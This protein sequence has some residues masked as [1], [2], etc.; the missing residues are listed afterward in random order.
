MNL[1]FEIL[2]F[3]DSEDYFDSLDLQVL[4]DKIKSWGFEPNI[5]LV[6]KAEDFA[7]EHPFEKYDLIVVDYDLQ[8][9]GEGSTLISGIRQQA[10]FTE[11]IFYSAK[12]ATDLWQLIHDNQLE[13]VYVANRQN[14]ETKIETVGKQSIKKVL[15]V[16]NMRGIVM[17]EVGLLDQI[18]DSI[19]LHGIDGLVQEKREIIFTSFHKQAAKQ[20]EKNCVAL[21]EFISSPTVQKMIDCCDSNKRWENINRLRKQ[22]QNLS[23]VTLGRYNEDIL[24]PRNYLAHGKP[25]KN[26]EN[27]YIFKYGEKEY[28]FTEEVGRELRSKIM[29]YKEAFQRMLEIVSP[30]S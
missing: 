18:M 6:R 23:V 8:D 26:G 10:I 16:E 15:D 22:N 28:E 20:S 2:W 4:M 13:G 21:S 24:Q 14:I 5:R 19:L 11:I 30:G 27:G 7:V 3:D 9:Y 12:P 29:G 17:A 1:G 25:V